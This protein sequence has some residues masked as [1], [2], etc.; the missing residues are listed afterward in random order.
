MITTQAQDTCDN[1]RMPAWGRVALLLGSWCATVLAGSACAR[2]RAVALPER[3]PLEVPA[4]PPR[5]V[6]ALGGDAPQPIT[7]PE[8]PRRPPLPRPPAARPEP[9]R[10]G[11]APRTEAPIAEVPKPP[12]E[13]SRPP[14]A[15]PTTLQTTPPAAQG[16]V[17]RA[18]RQTMTRATTDLGR[19]D[20]R[21]LDADGRTQYDT[22]KR[23]IQQAEDA[24]R[25]KNLVLAKNLADKAAV[26]AASQAGR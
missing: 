10:T 1:R 16:E 11:A 14:V 9:P 22:A 25:G 17:E 2:A 24:I 18:I 4:A 15:P 8:E 7:L 23:F 6:Q 26:I 21:A 20:Y 13:A 19:V 5:E 12:E 3:P